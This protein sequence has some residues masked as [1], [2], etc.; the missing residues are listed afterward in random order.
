M[1]AVRRRRMVIRHSSRTGTTVRS[2]T[3]KMPDNNDNGDEVD[4]ALETVEAEPPHIRE[5]LSEL[6][7]ELECLER[8]FGVKYARQAMEERVEMP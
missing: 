8:E 6:H 4:A 1:A 5:L 3:C 7:K 2:V